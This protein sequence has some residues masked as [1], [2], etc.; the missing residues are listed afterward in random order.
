M[1]LIRHKESLDDRKLLVSKYRLVPL[2]LLK[3]CPSSSMPWLSSQDWTTV[4]S[5]R[6]R[7]I[8]SSCFVCFY[9]PRQEEIDSHTTLPV[10]ND[11]CHPP[12]TIIS[13]KQAWC[14]ADG[15]Y[16]NIDIPDLGKVNTFCPLGRLLTASPSRL[17]L[18]IL[19]QQT[20]ALPQNE[21]PDPGL[22]FDTYVSGSLDDSAS[23]NI[24]V[25]GSWSAKGQVLCQ[26]FLQSH[27]PFFVVRQPSRWAILMFSFATLVIHRYSF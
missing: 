16:N 24:L 27:L 23:C 7:R 8:R 25:V 5:I 21:L 14:M 2:P 18:C 11:L 10:Y 15:S 17:A 1:D 26:C 13:N 9:N 6:P 3:L 4:H 20:H 12:A 22:V 19:V